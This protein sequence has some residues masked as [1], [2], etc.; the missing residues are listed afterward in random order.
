MS[1]SAHQRQNKMFW[2]VLSKPAFC[3]EDFRNPVAQLSLPV[4]F[5]S[6]ASWV[7]LSDF[8]SS[9]LKS[10]NAESVSRVQSPMS[11]SLSPFKSNCAFSALA[12]HNHRRQ[13]LHSILHRRKT[14]LTQEALDHCLFGASLHENFQDQLCACGFHHNAS[15]KKQSCA[16]MRMSSPAPHGFRRA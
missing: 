13:V 2:F 7:S 1:F 16:L 4:T 3:Q 15:R 11:S 8:S 9:V 5:D 12:S 14:L 6:I 10:S